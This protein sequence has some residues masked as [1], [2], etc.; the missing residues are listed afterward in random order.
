[1][2]RAGRLLIAALAAAAAGCCPKADVIR[3]PGKVEYRDKL[4]HVPIPADLTV[5]HEVAHGAL[6]ECPTVAAKRKA[7]IIV[8]NAHKRSIREIGQR[9]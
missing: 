7:E 4:V 6:S 2:S 1:M 5:E 8:C 3:L 9:R